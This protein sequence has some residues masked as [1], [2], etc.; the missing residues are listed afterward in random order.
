MKKIFILLI[1]SVLTLSLSACGWFGDDEP[2]DDV[3]NGAI[4]DDGNQNGND[5]DNGESGENGSDDEH[6]GDDNGD[7]GDESDAD[8]NDQDDEDG[9]D[10]DDEG[11][12]NGDNEEPIE[13]DDK[14]FY[15]GFWRVSG[16][17][18][19]D[20]RNEIIN[21]GD[22][23]NEPFPENGYY[24]EIFEIEVFDE[25]N[26]QRFIGR[27]F[28]N[29][30]SFEGESPDVGGYDFGSS[31]YNEVFFDDFFVKND[32]YFNEINVGDFK[33]NFFEGSYFKQSFFET[34]IREYEVNITNHHTIDYVARYSRL[35]E[36]PFQTTVWLD[37]TSANVIG[38]SANDNAGNEKWQT[39]QEGDYLTTY[40]PR[41]DVY[42]D[43]LVFSENPQIT[44]STFNNTETIQQFVR[45]EILFGGWDTSIF[46]NPRF[47]ANEGSDGSKTFSGRTLEFYVKLSDLL[48][49]Y[50]SVSPNTNAVNNNVSS[51]ASALFGNAFLNITPYSSFG[52]V[53]KST[54][55]GGREL[56]STSY[57]NEIASI[58]LND[59]D[60]SLEAYIR[61]AAGSFYGF[62]SIVSTGM[63][64]RDFL[65]SKAPDASDFYT[66]F[67]PVL[68]TIISGG[69]VVS[70]GGESNRVHDFLETS[71]F[72]GENHGVA[73][74]ETEKAN[75]LIL[76]VGLF[77]NGAPVSRSV[78]EV[79]EGLTSTSNS[80][81][82]SR[83]PLSGSETYYIVDETGAFVKRIPIQS[84]SSYFPSNATGNS[85]NASYKVTVE[86]NAVFV[87]PTQQIIRSSQQNV[88]EGD[89]VPFFGVEE[90][91]VFDSLQTAENKTFDQKT[92]Y[93]HVV[94]DGDNEILKP[95]EFEGIEFE[96]IEDI[97]EETLSSLQ[98][99]N[100]FELLGETQGEQ[101]VSATKIEN[102]VEELL[103]TE[104]FVFLEKEDV[105]DE[106][107]NLN[108]EFISLPDGIL[109][110]VEQRE[111]IF[112]VMIDDEEH[113]ALPSG[114]TTFEVLIETYVWDQIEMYDQ[115]V[116]LN[117]SDL[118]YGV[119]WNGE[120][121]F[122]TGDTEKTS[123]FY[124]EEE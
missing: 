78:Y 55:I 35:E 104:T 63:N 25:K 64:V 83:S 3:P 117:P 57:N 72:E 15:R 112:S 105:V 115:E 71:F 89:E 14:I 39:S 122:E 81:F 54:E 58:L 36:S 90:G 40:E 9:N 17:S 76:N 120:P 33:L 97:S 110:S 66:G 82:V 34:V 44:I 60:S 62:H 119:N 59:V 24:G 32:E 80:N 56:I 29:T 45:I 46:G 77:D 73:W 118:G 48:E 37:T 41:S 2:D 16:F 93:A 31:V 123:Y 113:T 124:I 75:A 11:D 18:L 19:Q 47:V 91:Y 121:V 26:A 108:T 50:E 23:E 74:E 27:I 67:S 21:F 52:S 103:P 114:A 99:F 86:G 106:L 98:G 12:E 88:L 51:I 102:V 87:N 10:Q 28:E 43:N 94:L 38:F 107:G 84:N 111:G 70:F 61:D 79:G 22:L 6:G 109:A 13:N 1:L 20:T 53:P 92:F 100:N 69:N 49:L 5:S 65:D 8:D 68:P 4:V 96:E 42:G 95:F 116:I 85:V 101:V 7:T 30:L